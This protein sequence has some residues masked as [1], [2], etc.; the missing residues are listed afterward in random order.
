MQPCSSNSNINQPPAPAPQPRPANSV[1]D[2]PA[3]NYE[4]E[5]VS[6]DVYWSKPLPPY[7]PPPPR[8]HPL[9]LATDPRAATFC[10]LNRREL[11]ACRLVKSEWADDIATRSR[12]RRIQ[13]DRPTNEPATQI[14]R[15]IYEDEPHCWR[16]AML[17]VVPDTSSSSMHLPA[18]REIGYF[19]IELVGFS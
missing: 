14:P 10:F 7:I 18:R 15:P 11:N 3:N 13:N 1:R 8:T 4:D 2:H 5:P 16:G 19:H 12:L 17:D 6:Q 9:R